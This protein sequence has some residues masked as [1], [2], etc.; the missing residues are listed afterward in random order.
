MSESEGEILKANTVGPG[1]VQVGMTVTGLDGEPVGKVKQVAETEFLID[2]PLARD[3]WVP[4]QS[5]MA[6]EG[7]GDGFRAVPPRPTEVVLAVTAAHVD[8]QGWRHP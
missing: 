2:R 8:A 6:A 3:L 4:Y 1:Q 5:V 7:H